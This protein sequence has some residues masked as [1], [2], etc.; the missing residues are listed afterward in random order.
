M[1]STPDGR[2]AGAP[3]MCKASQCGQTAT[4]R[5]ERFAHAGRPRLPFQPTASGQHIVEDRNDSEGD[6]DNGQRN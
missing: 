6:E 3:S 1:P 5:V 4:D 2:Y